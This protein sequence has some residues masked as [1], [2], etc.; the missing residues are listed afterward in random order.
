MNLMK[1]NVRDVN[2]QGENSRFVW[3][4]QISR[5]HVEFFSL[6]ILQAA[7]IRSNSVSLVCTRSL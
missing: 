1:V 2:D 4:H 6:Q 7:L 5:L 3:K